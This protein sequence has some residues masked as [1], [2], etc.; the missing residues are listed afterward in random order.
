MEITVYT[1]G[2]CREQERAGA[3]V[4]IL[5]F[6]GSKIVLSGKEK[7]T[8]HNRMELTAVLQAIEYIRDHISSHSAIKIYSDSQYVVNLPARKEK[9]TA[10]HYIT[11]K[12]KELNN[13]DL[14][15]IFFTYLNEY[16]VELLKIK[17]HQKKSERINYNIEA[18]ILSRKLVRES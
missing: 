12:G 16:P 10:A 9:L 15:K 6:R 1:D 3:W 17:A 5:L 13:S 4:A 14:L 11:K 2:S 7:C 8:T 18:D